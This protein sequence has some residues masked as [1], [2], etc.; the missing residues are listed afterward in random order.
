MYLILQNN[1]EQQQPDLPKGPP[2]TVFVGNI[3]DRAPDTLVRQILQ[4]S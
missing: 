3:T 2:V 1:T 4:V